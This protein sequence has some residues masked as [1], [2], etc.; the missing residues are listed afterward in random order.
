MVIMFY[1]IKIVADLDRHINIWLSRISYLIN[2][3]LYAR[4]HNSYEAV[5]SAATLQQFQGSQQ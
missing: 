5:E 1:I 3:G 2:L 4:M